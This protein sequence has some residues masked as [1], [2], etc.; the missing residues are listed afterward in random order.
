MRTTFMQTNESVERKWYVVD[1]T[2]LVLGRMATD[3]AVVLKGKHKPTYTPHVDCGD[4]VIIVNAEK[5]AL[6]TGQKVILNDNTKYKW[7]LR[8]ENGTNYVPESAWS[9]LQSW[10]VD[11]SGN[12]TFILLKSDN[13]NFDWSVDSNNVYDYFTIE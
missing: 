5:I 3:V 1:A 6:T 10:T 9:S 2:E 4:Y 8:L 7:A 13:A 11:K 12:Y